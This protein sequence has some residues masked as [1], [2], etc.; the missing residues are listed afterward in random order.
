M[1]KTAGRS[2][3][4]HWLCRHTAIDLVRRG[5][6]ILMRRFYSCAPVCMNRWEMERGSKSRDP[7]VS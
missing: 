1:V 6:P 5:D 7:Y 2:S 3:W 4:L